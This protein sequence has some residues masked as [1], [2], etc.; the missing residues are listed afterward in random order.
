VN[1][2]GKSCDIALQLA[3]DAA[4]FVRILRQISVRERRADL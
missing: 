1:L 3:R 4:Q 2:G